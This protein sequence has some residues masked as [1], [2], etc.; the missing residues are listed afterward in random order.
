M[1]LARAQRGGQ[2]FKGALHRRER[3]AA[4]DDGRQLPVTFDPGISGGFQLSQQLSTALAA[5]G[6]RQD[7]PTIRAASATQAALPTDRP[8][9]PRPAP[10]RRRPASGRLDL[11]ADASDLPDLLAETPVCYQLS[12]IDPGLDLLGRR[13]VRQSGAAAQRANLAGLDPARGKPPP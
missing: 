11:D 13:I 4:A 1:A 8:L 10:A 5:G 2:P 9:R 3:A 7:L 6:A 12:E